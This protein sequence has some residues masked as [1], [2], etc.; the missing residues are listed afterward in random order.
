M[1]NTILKIKGSFRKSYKEEITEGEVSLEN[2]KTYILFFDVDKSHIVV[3]TIDKDNKNELNVEERIAIIESILDKCATF[4]NSILK[5]SI[6]LYIE[7]YKL[8]DDTTKEYIIPKDN[9]CQEFVKAPFAYDTENKALKALL[10]MYMQVSVNA[11]N[12]GKKEITIKVP[13][14]SIVGRID[15]KHFF[16][17]CLIEYAN[18]I[19]IKQVEN[20]SNLLVLVPLK[21][22]DKN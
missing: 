15:A 6:S 18:I 21:K 4:I 16:P 7:G 2:G 8:V 5:A 10:N 19:E 12:I 17:Y 13:D 11:E 20:S 22:E 3:K 9:I 14:T 1:K